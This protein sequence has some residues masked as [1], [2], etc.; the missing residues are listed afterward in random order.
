MGQDECLVFQ[1]ILLALFTPLQGGHLKVTCK[2]TFTLVR[3]PM[4]GL[5]GLRGSVVNSTVPS[6]SYWGAQGN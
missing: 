5:C 3:M 1:P 6:L 4:P 2:L